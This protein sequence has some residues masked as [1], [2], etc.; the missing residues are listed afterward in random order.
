MAAWRRQVADLTYAAPRSSRRLGFP[1]R[2]MSWDSDSLVER[3][4][5]PRD[6]VAEFSLDLTERTT[7]DAAEPVARGIDSRIFLFAYSSSVNTNQGARASHHWSGTATQRANVQRR[8]RSAL[9]SRRRPA[10]ISIDVRLAAWIGLERVLEKR[11][12]PRRVCPKNL[13]TGA[14]TDRSARES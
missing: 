7:C 2:V 12:A 9:T 6:M 10:I 3:E 14:S 5:A 11:V 4:Q 8:D 13:A 1:P